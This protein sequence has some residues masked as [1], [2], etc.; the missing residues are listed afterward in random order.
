MALAARPNWLGW[1]LRSFIMGTAA[2]PQDGPVSEGD[3]HK[4]RQHEHH[5]PGLRGVLWHDFL[6]I[7]GAQARRAAWVLAQKWAMTSATAGCSSRTRCPALLTVSR[8]AFGSNCCQ[9][10]ACPS[11]LM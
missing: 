2:N 10:L 6:R 4:Q 7:R 8:R 11:G 5:R 9:T 1:R 3:D